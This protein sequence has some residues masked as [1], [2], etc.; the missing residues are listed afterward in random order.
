MSDRK[1]RKKERRDTS[2]PREQIRDAV[3][4]DFDEQLAEIKEHIKDLGVYTEPNKCKDQY[5][6]WLIEQLEDLTAL[7]PD[8]KRHGKYWS[9]VPKDWLNDLETEC[10]EFRHALDWISFNSGHLNLCNK[11][12]D[13]LG[14][15][16]QSRATKALEEK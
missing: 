2:I 7:S 1:I 5:I 15:E 8:T 3:K 12:E 14:C 4:S 13:C 16:I 6:V 11:S 10:K 9:L